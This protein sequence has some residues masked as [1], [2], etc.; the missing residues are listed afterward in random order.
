MPRYEVFWDEFVTYSVF[1][2][3]DTIEDARKSWEDPACWD[4]EIEVS[5]SDYVGNVEIE[6]V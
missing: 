5:G 2:E 6:E 3:A 1:V 4:S